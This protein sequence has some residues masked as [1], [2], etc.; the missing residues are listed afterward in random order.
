[1]DR[2][3]K[4]VLLDVLKRIA[5]HPDDDGIQAKRV[6]KCCSLCDIL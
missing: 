6:S 1:M 5:S 4:G 3:P 2:S